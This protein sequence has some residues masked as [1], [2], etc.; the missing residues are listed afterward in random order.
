MIVV[1]GC[2]DGRMRMPGS[3]YWLSYLYTGI[4][5]LLLLGSFL[6]LYPLRRTDGFGDD[7]RISIGANLFDLVLAVL[8][9]QPLVLS[10][11]RNAV[12]WRNRLDYREVIRRIDRATDQVDIWK[13]WTGL[14]EPA[15]EPAFTAAV[16]AA[17]D[18]GVH[19]RIM[20]TDP[21][22]PDAAERARQVAPTDAVALMR[23]NIE[24]LDE[25]LRGLPE[26]H[27]ARFHVRISPVGPA[28]VF[29][30]VDDWLS[31]GLF[32]DRRMSE[33]HQREVRVHGD[34]GGLALE[35]FTTRWNAPGLRGI[36]DHYRL[37]LRFTVGG[38]VIEHDLRYVLHEGEHWVD[39][40]PGALTHAFH[41]DH[42]VT[43]TAD[44]TQ[45]YV[46][47]EAG[48]ATRE[49]VLALYT[50]KYGPGHGAVLLRLT[51]FRSRRD[52]PSGIMPA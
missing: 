11:N 51:V 14:L 52:D 9:L 47:T 5:V 43:L 40:N 39:V 37:S 23:Q 22:S 6:L 8:V 30:R 33:N 42:E 1:P 16:R 41:P 18:R 20:L 45:P 35:A 26:R 3:R 48:P 46:L 27:R 17:L 50:A 4:G 24:R 32:R 15:H 13:H 12:R 49:R 19:F 29:Y 44:G 31:Y 28:H 21:S 7:L 25:F 34:V 36:A 38:E 2:D 10:L